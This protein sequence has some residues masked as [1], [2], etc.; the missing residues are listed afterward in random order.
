MHKEAALIPALPQYLD[1][2]PTAAAIK[3]MQI[4][5]WKGMHVKAQIKAST[6]LSFFQFLSFITSHIHTD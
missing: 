2:P 1:P 3:R 4:L 5:R 6:C